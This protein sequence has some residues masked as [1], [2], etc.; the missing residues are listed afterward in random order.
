MR[1]DERGKRSDVESIF[2]LLIWQKEYLFIASVCIVLYS[3]QLVS[4]ST[5]TDQITFIQNLYI[6]LA[7]IVSNWNAV[8]F[9]SSPKYLTK[10][11][12]TRNKQKQR[13]MSAPVANALT[14]ASIPTKIYQL[15]VKSAEPFVPKKLQPL[16]NHAAGNHFSHRISI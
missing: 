1:F 8:V 14:K 12:I 13:I 3:N 5:T 4:C 16:W 15:I 6:W 11:L 9:S 2:F 10:S 7:S